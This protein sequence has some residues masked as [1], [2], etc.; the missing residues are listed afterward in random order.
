[1]YSYE[2][3]CQEYSD[4]SDSQVKKSVK[5]AVIFMASASG[6]LSEMSAEVKNVPWRQRRAFAVLGMLMHTLGDVYAH[7]T[8][9][10]KSNFELPTTKCLNTRFDAR[11]AVDILSG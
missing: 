8:K 6:P 4:K 9:V 10:P 11:F 5:E 7:K 1:M 2:P 3:D